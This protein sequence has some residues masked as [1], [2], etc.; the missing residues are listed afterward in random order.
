MICDNNYTEVSFS[1]HRVKKCGKASHLESCRNH[2]LA[3]NYGS[4]Y[5]NHQARIEH[6]WRNRIE[7]RVGICTRMMTDVRG[8]AD[9]LGRCQHVNEFEATVLEILTAKRRQGYARHSHE[10]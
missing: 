10:S 1:W 4:K 5:C 9:V 3:S 7:E 2:R 6:A 8:F